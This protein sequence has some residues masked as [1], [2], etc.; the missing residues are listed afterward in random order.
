MHNVLGGYLEPQQS[1]SL[2]CLRED[3]S[4]YTAIVHRVVL[5]GRRPHCWLVV[6]L[7]KASAQK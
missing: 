7:R 3:A 2:P 1:S 5:S 4:P 6:V